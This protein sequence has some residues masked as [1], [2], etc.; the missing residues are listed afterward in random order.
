M[1]FM[2]QEA[3]TLMLVFIGR[4][5]N[6]KKCN[7]YLLF[8]QL[9]IDAVRLNNY[10]GDFCTNLTIKFFAIDSGEM[11]NLCNITNEIVKQSF[12]HLLRLS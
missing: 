1:T 3:L 11:M 7:L 2:F 10:N 5:L 12:R 8:C 9:P 6:I 4:F